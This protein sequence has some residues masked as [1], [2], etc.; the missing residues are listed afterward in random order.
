[1]NTVVRSLSKLENDIIAGWVDSGSSVLD[2]GCGNGE[3]LSRLI[4]EKQVHAQ[5][6]ELSA[7]AIQR[8]VA[9]GLSV[10]QED[11][12]T[13]LSEYAPKS[14][15]YIVLN[16]TFQQVKKPAF[17]LQEALRVGKHAI[18]GFPNFVYVRSRFQ[19]FFNGKV[20]VTS[21]LPYKWYNTP[22][23]HFLSIA[24]FREYCQRQKVHIEQAAF[25]A[26]NKHVHFLPNLF[27]EIGLFLLS[28][29]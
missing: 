7:Q 27:A 24:D 21:S 6:I 17:V 3:L 13:G 25:V 15:D 11:I 29:P 19:I 18:V 12:D 1:M 28:K 14:F 10:F 20:P 26:G 23:R 16:Q 4:R 8:C 22:N 9:S 2:L 5:G